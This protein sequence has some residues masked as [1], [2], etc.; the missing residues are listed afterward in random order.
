MSSLDRVIEG[1]DAGRRV[2]WAKYYQTRNLL[3]LA[4]HVI[5]RIR[6]AHLV[7]HDAQANRYLPA[8]HDRVVELFYDPIAHRWEGD[9]WVDE[10]LDELDA[11]DDMREHL[12]WPLKPHP[13]DRS[14]S[15]KWLSRRCA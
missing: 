5:Y 9:P 7:G 8:V 15:R 4:H 14:P 12:G 3:L 13:L 2:A 10:A 1:V 6:Q 11:M